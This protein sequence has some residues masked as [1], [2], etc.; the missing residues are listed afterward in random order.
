MIALRPA[1]VPDEGLASLRREA[2]A[3][4]REPFAGH[5]VPLR[6][7][8]IGLRIP[9]GR[10]GGHCVHGRGGAFGAVGSSACDVRC[11]KRNATIRE[12]Q[13]IVESGG[14]RLS[15]AGKCS[16]H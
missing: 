11:G 4:G 6:A 14:A 5:R 13:R 8:A 1:V 7:E 2:E 12:T 15:Q 16:G 3:K 10:S 9:S